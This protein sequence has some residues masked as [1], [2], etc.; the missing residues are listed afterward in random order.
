MD[1]DLAAARAK[2]AQ[3]GQAP[4]AAMEQQLKEQQQQQAME[5]QKKA[6]LLGILDENARARIA[7]IAAVKPEK[8]SMVENYVLMLAQKGQIS[9][10]V[11]ESKIIEILDQLA[12]N[13]KKTKIIVKRRTI[14]S[15][16]EDDNDDD[17]M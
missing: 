4:G 8:A 7:R 6:M 5:E 9:S 12:A 15:E 17:L 16:D 10:T 14:D 1:A 2:A 11:N 3:G 13:Q